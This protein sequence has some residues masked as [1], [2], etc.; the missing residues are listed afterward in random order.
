[1]VCGETLFFFFFACFEY[2]ALC[3]SVFFCFTEKRRF[4]NS[5]GVVQCDWLVHKGN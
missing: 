3:F 1:M 2:F 5:G 4:G